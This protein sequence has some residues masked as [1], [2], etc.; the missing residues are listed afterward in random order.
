MWPGQL[1]ETN[2]IALTDS[3]LETLEF[4]FTIFPSNILVIQ[5][6]PTSDQRA[7][8]SKGTHLVVL[9]LGAQMAKYFPF[10]RCPPLFPPN[11]SIALGWG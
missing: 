1:R 5:R 9:L 3:H 2:F 7:A 10:M 8:L 4:N 11:K 6:H